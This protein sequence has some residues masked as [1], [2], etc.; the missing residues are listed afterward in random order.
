MVIQDKIVVVSGGFDP[1]HSGHIAMINT[2]RTIGRVIIAL[3]SDDWL[4]RKKGKAFLPFKERYQILSAL[5]NVMC[6][7]AFDDSDGS[8]RDA[9][10]KAKSL[11]PHSQICFVN[12]GDRTRDNIP[13]MDVED[14]EF[15]FGVGG[16]N[17]ANSSSWILNSWKTDRTDRPWGHY[18]VIEK[19]EGAKVKTLNVEA[20]KSLSMQRHQHRSE[21]WTVVSG[22][23][24]VNLDGVIHK[25]YPG[26]MIKIPAGS[27]HQL[28]ARK[29]MKLVEVQMGPVCEESDIERR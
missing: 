1:L 13:E 18:T 7:I 27:W 12:G 8:A 4:A 9:L 24:Y 26:S 16:D 17:K 29:E 5:K 10:V 6:V 23:G 15:M 25:L 2:A 20:G 28:H 21:H 22:N 11:F 19:V 14:V 3:N